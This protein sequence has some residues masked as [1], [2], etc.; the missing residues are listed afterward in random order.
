[1]KRIFITTRILMLLS[2][3]LNTTAQTTVKGKLFEKTSAGEM[4]LPFANVF[5]KGT[6]TGA[7]TDLDGNYA[8]SIEAGTYTII[9][10]F[11][12]YSPIEKNFEATGEGE[13]TINATLSADQTALQEVTVSAKANR[14]SENFLVL[15]Q[16]KAVIAVENIGAIEMSAKGVSDAAG[17]V[18]KVTGISKQEGDGTLN[19]RG[20]GDRY[21]TTT[22]NRLPLPANE[23]G[24]KNVDLK[25]FSTDVIAAINIEKTYS[26]PLN[27]DFGGANINIVS[28]KL[29]GKPFLE[30]EVKSSTHQ[31]VWDYDDMYLPELPNSSGFYPFDLPNIDAIRSKESYEFSHSW[32]PKTYTISPDMGIGLSGGK[33]FNIGQGKLNTFFTLSFENERNVVSKI[34]KMISATGYHIKDSEGQEYSYSTQT[35][36][37]L[38]LN[39][40]LKNSNFYVNSLMLNSSNAEMTTLTGSING[41]I[42][43]G[44]KRRLS[45]EQNFI[46][47]NQLLGEHEL[48][49]GFNINWGIAYNYVLNQIPDRRENL[50]NTYLAE[51]KTG[52]LDTESSAN[53][54]FW[55]KFDDNEAAANL[56]VSKTFGVESTD[57]YK[58]KL[59][60]GY[61]GK[62]KERIF[63][64]YQFNHWV[65]NTDNIYSINTPDKFF[66][67]DN[68]KNNEFSIILAE[69]RDEQGVAIDGEGYDGK[70]SV[71][72]G[73]LLTEYNINDRLMVLL[74]ARAESV[75]L[76]INTRSNQNNGDIPGT[77]V[78][79]NNFDDFKILP[80]MSIKYSLSDKQN[81]RFAASKT[82]TL[83]QLQ[84]LPKLAFKYDIS[85]VIY[86][87][88][89][90]TPSDIYNAD[91]K[92]EIF[93]NA[94][95]LLS[96]T[97]FGKYII[98]PI[99]QT[100]FGGLDGQYV[101]ANTGDWAYVYGLELDTKKDL[102]KRGSKKV[103][104]SGNMSLMETETEID[105]DKMQDKSG[106]LY[107]TSF[108]SDRS[109]LQG[110]APLLANLSLGYAS[111]W[112][113]NTFSTN[114][115]YN[116]VSKKLFAF[117]QDDVGDEY[118]AAMHTLD[119]IVKTKFKKLGIDLK[120]KNLLDAE[121][122][123]FVEN[124]IEEN[125]DH[126][127]RQYKQGIS[128][129]LTA[130]YRF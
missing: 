17:A 104:V 112:N 46:L 61:S 124:R 65:R 58:A 125:A 39:Y 1:M 92:W 49:N 52:E 44:L 4:S 87:N 10:S 76:E 38:N 25:L 18:T 68:F 66:Q 83:P 126:V 30:L 84:E 121:Y 88:P 74:G 93:P 99:N 120:V 114:L 122:Q 110:A 50:Y 36:G 118:E 127:I 123:R 19:V 101:T 69:A 96:V 14:E 53:Y 98:D 113:E 56:R 115:V 21:N 90:L 32:A 40:E 119:F 2:L 47:V 64:S 117:G 54:R 60:L 80:S 29:T 35:N 130:K 100:T 78:L 6:T 57:T 71:N 75:S 20:L 109:K 105:G 24:L 26:S 95:E 67:Y 106:G 27:G 85:D 31:N 51:N 23:A 22:L 34:D 43:N 91:L 81:I 79:T 5:V 33:T 82:Y 70:V 63:N 62:T 73:F 9:F 59:T 42:E 107:Y 72:G 86:G 3:A 41:E 77:N 8:L 94:G 116:Y 102:Y 7:I 89:N 108:N 103:F 129:S 16:K 111:K 12:G 45:L 37:M 128:L 15:E 48:N 11:V 13:V 55:Q 97:A 28:K